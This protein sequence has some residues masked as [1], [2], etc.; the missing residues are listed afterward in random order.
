VDRCQQCRSDDVMMYHEP[1]WGFVDVCAE[2]D[3]LMD[4]ETGEVLDDGQAW[5]FRSRNDSG[6]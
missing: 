2:C 3:A 4:A 6:V 5:Q 1:G